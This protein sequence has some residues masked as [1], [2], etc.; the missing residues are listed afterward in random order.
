MN[1]SHAAGCPKWRSTRERERS[2]YAQRRGAGTGPGAEAAA[3][4]NRRAGRPC[5][6][7][8]FLRQEDTMRARP[9]ES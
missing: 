9:A 5:S 8:Q 2:G 4:G 7:R 1:R 3:R 6:C